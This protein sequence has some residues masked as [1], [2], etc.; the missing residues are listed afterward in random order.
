MSKFEM[1]NHYN[2]IHI[3]F[4]SGMKLLLTSLDGECFSE[5]NGKIL[6]IDN[7]PILLLA[8]LLQMNIK[9]YLVIHIWIRIC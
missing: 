4:Y 8:D 6:D 7:S 3:F 2:N 1:Y 5:L 9:G